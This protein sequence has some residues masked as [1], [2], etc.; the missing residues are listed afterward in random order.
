[1]LTLDTDLSI[2]D[3]GTS[4]EFRMGVLRLG[5]LGES[6]CSSVRDAAAWCHQPLCITE[7]ATSVAVAIMTSNGEGFSP[8]VHIKIER[9]TRESKS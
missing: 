1:M 8:V 9:E 5:V 4:T 3:L 6:C 7:E 2:L